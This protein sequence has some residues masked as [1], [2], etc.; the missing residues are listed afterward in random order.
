MNKLLL[1]TSNKGKVIEIREALGALP[2]SILSF[3]DLVMSITMPEENGTT[4]AD[5][6]LIKAR[7]IFAQTGI[8]SLAD[9]SGIVVEALANELGVETRR[10]G[11]GPNASDEEWIQYFLERMGTEEN[12]AARFICNLAL[13]D[14]DGDE[15]LF[16]GVC[17]GEITA[18]LEADYLPGLPIS[19]CFKPKGYDHVYSALS[20]EEKNRISHRGRATAKLKAYLSGI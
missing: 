6:A 9:D 4:Y 17:D 8:P 7:S 13:V 2:L 20:V 5:N 19:A 12:R 11:A 10:W 1:A 18:T 14:A 15:H 3:A 16:E